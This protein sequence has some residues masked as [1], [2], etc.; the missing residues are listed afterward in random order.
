MCKKEVKKKGKL[1]HMSKDQP[2]YQ[3]P[4]LIRQAVIL[5]EP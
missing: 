4:F 5:K 2:Q 3:S 1:S